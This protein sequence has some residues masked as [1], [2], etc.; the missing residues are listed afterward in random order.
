VL[1]AWDR[2]IRLLCIA[3]Q[4]FLFL[5]RVRTLTRDIDIAMLSVCLSVRSSRSIETAS[6]I[7]VVSS[8]HGSPIIL[9]L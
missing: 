1:G 5:S 6:H 7:V 8:P 4:I 2:E 3:L 9:V